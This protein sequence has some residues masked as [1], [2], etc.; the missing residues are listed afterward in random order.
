[1]PMD[2]PTIDKL[3]EEELKRHRLLYAER[4]LVKAG[5]YET[6]ARSLLR[7]KYIGLCVG[8]AA[9]IGFLIAGGL[10]YAA[11][12][13]VA[14]VLDYTHAKRTY[15]TLVRWKQLASESPEDQQA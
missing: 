4:Q 13:S 2:A 11:V 6:V 7:R 14:T 8:V 9:A 12:A 1:M 10:E 3:S 5:E 15:E